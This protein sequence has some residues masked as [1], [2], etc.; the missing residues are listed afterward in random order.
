MEI[1]DLVTELV[2]PHRTAGPYEARSMRVC[3]VIVTH[4]RPQL[5]KQCLAAVLAQST[6]VEGILVLD[7]ASTPP[8][9]ELLPELAP[10]VVLCRFAAN[11]GGA[12]GFYHGLA[13]A[14]RQGF[15]AAWLMDDDGKPAAECLNHLLQAVQR[16]AVDFASPLVV[17]AQ[18]ERQ[19]AFGLDLGN[20]RLGSVAQACAAAGSDGL[21]LGAANPFNGTLIT[22]RAYQRLGDIKFECF[23]WGDEEEYHQRALRQGLKVAVTIRAIHHHPSAKG[24]SVEFGPRRSVLKICPPDR[25]HLHYRNLGYN[26]ARYRGL[27]AVAYRAV[28]HVGYFIANR[29][30]AELR[31]FLRY[32]WDGALDRYRLEPSRVSLRE[33]LR[34]CSLVRMRRSSQFL[35]QEA[36]QPCTGSSR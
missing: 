9:H 11:T 4:N 13:D 35:S 8:V 10:Q 24:A 17:S 15:D 28:L 34:A 23:I 36:A 2:S 12:G 6:P 5:L 25:A 22:R 7:N 18:D 19:L 3:A 30:F 14:F 32:Y 26:T 1:A 31:K 27:P 21:L 29:Q 20:Q 16:Q 33:R